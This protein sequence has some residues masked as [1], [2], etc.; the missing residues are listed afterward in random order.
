MDKAKI[1]NSIFELIRIFSIIMIILS[2]YSIHAGVNASDLPF[3]LNSI[4]LNLSE[5][6]NLG[7]VIFMM[8]SGFFMINSTKFSFEKVLRIVLES[9][10]YIV[11]FYFISISLGEIEFSWVE[12]YKTSLFLFLV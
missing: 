1:R 12:F 11:T 5:L 9:L 2:H 6:G 7:V 10:F 4:V 3:G 8:I